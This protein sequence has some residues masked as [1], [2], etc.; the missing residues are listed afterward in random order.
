MKKLKIVDT[1]IWPAR[2]CCPVPR[3]EFMTSNA[4]ESWN[5]KNLWARTNARICEINSRGMV[6]SV[7]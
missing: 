4:A 1:K 5:K 3:Y 6:H 2:V 7:A